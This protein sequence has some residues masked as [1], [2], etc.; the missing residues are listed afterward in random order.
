MATLSI[1][2]IRGTISPITCVFETY[3]VEVNGINFDGP[4]TKAVGCQIRY[5]TVILALNVKVETN[6][7]HPG[8]QVRS[9]LAIFLGE[10][11]ERPDHH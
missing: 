7:L 3:V 8:R 9:G 2:V 10:Q 6:K 4:I 11:E 5:L 1:K